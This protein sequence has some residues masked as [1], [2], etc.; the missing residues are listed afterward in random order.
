VRRR[1]DQ[2]GT[3]RPR[4]WF[5]EILLSYIQQPRRGG[6]HERKSL[7]PG[8]RG[9]SKIRRELWLRPCYRGIVHCQPFDTLGN[10]PRHFGMALRD[11]L[12]AV[13]VIV[14]PHRY[15]PK[16]CAQETGPR[17]LPIPWGW[18]RVKS[19]RRRPYQ[20]ITGRLPDISCALI[21]RRMTTRGEV[22]DFCA[23]LVS[24]A[25]RPG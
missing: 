2:D 1:H 4:G 16:S 22:P 14:S 21:G 13:S 5:Y 11:L 18:K 15:L 20:P 24:V 7:L 23:R 10:H 3:S 17:D 19:S 9:G 12:R 8:P 25:K 6:E